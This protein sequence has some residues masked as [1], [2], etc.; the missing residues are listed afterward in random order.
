MNLM[1]NVKVAI[2]EDKC[3]IL[4][5]NLFPICHIPFLSVLVNN[6]SLFDI[7]G[8][9]LSGSILLS[10]YFLCKILHLIWHMNW[11][12]PNCLI[13]QLCLDCLVGRR[14]PNGLTVLVF[15]SYKCLLSV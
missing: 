12:G 10:H 6:Y 8:C 5:P 2:F 14:K 7:S 1:I 13:Y 9:S 4:L 15:Q 11:R 3:Y